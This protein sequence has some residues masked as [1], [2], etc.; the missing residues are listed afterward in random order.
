MNATIDLITKKLNLEKLV[1]KMRLSGVVKH[2]ITAFLFQ[3]LTDLH[4]DIKKQMAYSLIKCRITNA[5]ASL[6]ENQA[7]VEGLMDIGDDEEAV[8][9][10][11]LSAFHDVADRMIPQLKAEL[12]IIEKD[13]ILF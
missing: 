12:E 4:T 6:G 1:Q 11:I 3:H 7:F 8:K 9:I 2:E 13:E 5:L 10:A